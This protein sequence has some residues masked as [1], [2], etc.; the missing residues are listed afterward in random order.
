[1]SDTP[2]TDAALKWVNDGLGHKFAYVSNFAALCS[3]L[4]RENTALRKMHDNMLKILATLTEDKERLDWL[5]RY[6]STDDTNQLFPR[7][8]RADC[9]SIREAI[10]AARKEE[11]KL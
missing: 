6:I 10:D 2:R 3:E 4:E 9:H 11:A 1:M 8:K 5:D 7:I